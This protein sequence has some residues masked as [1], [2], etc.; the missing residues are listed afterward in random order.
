MPIN[1][2][3]WLR[4]AGHA[5]PPSMAG[6]LQ[7]PTTLPARVG[8]LARQVAQG[9]PSEYDAVMAVQT[10]IQGHTRYNLDVAA[11]PPGVDSVDRFLFVTRE[12]FCEQ[13]ASSMAVMLRTLGI[14]TRLVTGYGPGDR[15]PLTGYFEVRDSDAH[16]WLEVYYPQIG[17]VPYDPTFGVPAAA[18]SVASRFMAGPGLRGDRPVR[19]ACGPAAGEACGGRGV[20]RGGHDRSRGAPRLAGRGPGAA[21]AGGGRG[22]LA[23]STDAP[24]HAGGSRGG[25]VRRAHAGPG[26]RRPRPRGDTRRPASIWGPWRGTT[27]ST[28][29]SSPRQRR[30]C[31]RSSAHASAPRPDK[32]SPEEVARARAMLERVRERA[33]A[34]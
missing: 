14:P 30:S 8:D 11:D 18:P 31:E 26:A 5:I 9:A 17:W 19:A 12:G 25:D 7:V 27:R 21:R 24:A 3:S 6:Y 32:P 2:P 33:G 22:P 29:R 13:I 16:A 15:N 10:W 34:R 1:D 28:A 4:R 20:G 23:P